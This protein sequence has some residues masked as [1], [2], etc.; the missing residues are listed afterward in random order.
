MNWKESY[1]DI[2]SELRIMQIQK[3]EISRRV[4]MAHRV[5]VSGS[6]PSSGGYCHIPLDKGLEKYDEV[7]AGYREVETEITRLLSV[8]SAMEAE[9][10]KFT[11]LAYVVQCKRLEGKGYKQIGME[12]G[13]SEAYLR[14]LISEGNKEVTHSA[15]AS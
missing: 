3:M 14:K 12:T 4:E 9:M 7:V 13:H 6:I 11:G 2:C 15:K 8:K 10:V 5:V 1:N